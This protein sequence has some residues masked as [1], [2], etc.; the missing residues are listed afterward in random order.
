M[1]QH[2]QSPEKCTHH[3][4]FVTVRPLDAVNDCV[5]LYHAGHRTSAHL[6]TWQYLPYGPFADETA[7]QVW[8]TERQKQT[9][10]LFHTVCDAQSGRPV[11][12]ITIMS[13]VPE[14]GRAELGHIWYDVDI[15]RTSLTTEATY[16]LLTYLFDQLHY[17][18]VEWKCDAHNTRSRNAAQRLGFS[19]EGTFR[20]HMLV[21]EQNR[22]T[23]WFSM[24]DNE[25]PHRKARF[26]AFLAGTSKRL[27]H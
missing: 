7:L 6:Y 24:L 12:M 22:D 9:D 4:H 26:R 27:A 10:P 15:Q 16:L 14:F 19:Y 3:G 5:A 17:R 21:K 18:R 23:A 11:G 20:Q 8:L 25:W 2:W 1:I 13:I